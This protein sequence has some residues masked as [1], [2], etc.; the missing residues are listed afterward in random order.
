MVMLHLQ[1]DPISDLPINGRHRTAH[2][3]K[4]PLGDISL[5]L[6]EHELGGKYAIRSIPY[7]GSSMINI[8]DLEL[9]GKQV[10]Q[11][12]LVIRL[13][14]EYFQQEIIEDLTAQKLLMDCTIA[15]LAGQRIVAHA[16]R[17]NLAKRA[18]I[19]TI[20]GVPFLMIYKFQFG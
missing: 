13:S 15:N 10:E 4:S 19:K 12:N 2:Y 18:S 8:C 17:L 9:V 7:H 11:N 1:I 6:S 5:E 14:K 20:S 16:I 3:F